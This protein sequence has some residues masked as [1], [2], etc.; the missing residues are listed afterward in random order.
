MDALVPVDPVQTTLEIQVQDR[1]DQFVEATVSTVAASSAR[2]YRQTFQLWKVWCISAG[3]DPLLLMAVHVREFL[4]AQSV[5]Q[6]TRQ[7]QLSALRK[8]ARVLAILDY[9]IPA[10]R[11]AYE[12]LLL[13]R[14]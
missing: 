2:I 14:A 1:Y 10:R 7:G 3:R 11:A 4:V 12:S 8:M 13:L 9:N 5:S 6:S